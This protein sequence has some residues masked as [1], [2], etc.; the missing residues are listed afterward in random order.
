M[1][2][3]VSLGRYDIILKVNL[4]LSSQYIIKP[5]QFIEEPSEK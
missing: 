1:S 2:A 3:K 4:R 5:P